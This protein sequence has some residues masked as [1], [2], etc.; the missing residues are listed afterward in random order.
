MT[1][2]HIPELDSTGLRKFA[3]TTAIVLILLFAFLLP[4]IFGFSFPL[5][6]WIGGSILAAW[7][8]V[9][10]NTL[11]PVYKLWMKFGLI[12]SRITTPVILGVV[13][14]LVLSPI[15]FVMRMFGRDPLSIKLDN[16]ADSYRVE[17]AKP[18]YKRQME[19]PF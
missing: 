13:Y 11:N 12:M 4:W 14:F 10:P 15:A 9:A 3:F 19:K 17:S 1:L 8:L 6:P 18:D 7:G 5:W 16:E 2:H